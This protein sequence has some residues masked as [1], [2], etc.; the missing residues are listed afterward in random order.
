MTDAKNLSIL[1]ANK[2]KLF[3]KSLFYSSGDKDHKRFNR[4]ENQGEAFSTD[5]PFSP[6]TILH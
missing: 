5:N 2:A 3:A 1:I 6:L 4:E